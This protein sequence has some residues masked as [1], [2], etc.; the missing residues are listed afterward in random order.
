VSAALTEAEVTPA[1]RGGIRRLDKTA[2]RMD[3]T[4][5]VQLRKRRAACPQASLFKH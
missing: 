5:C 4:S 1:L 3:V 2:K